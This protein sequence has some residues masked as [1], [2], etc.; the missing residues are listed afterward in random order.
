MVGAVILDITYG[1]Q[2]QEQDDYLVYLIQRL[3]AAFLDNLLPGK[4]LVDTFPWRALYLHF[5][6]SISF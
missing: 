3:V 6:T 1:Y 2:V 4:H 5:L